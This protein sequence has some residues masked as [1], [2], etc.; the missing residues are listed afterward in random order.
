M[1][2]IPKVLH[3]VTDSSSSA[4][5]AATIKSWATKNPDWKVNVWCNSQSM[6]QNHAV[7]GGQ[8]PNVEVKPID[9]NLVPGTSTSTSS[10]S[11]SDVM[12]LAIL[13]KYGGC[14]IDTD[15][16]PADPLPS[17]N[18]SDNTA[19][20][21]PAKP[22]KQRRA[23]MACTI[24]SQRVRSLLAQTITSNSVA[25]ERSAMPQDT[26]L[27]DHCFVTTTI[28]ASTTTT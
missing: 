18:A 14:A 5:T 21:V 16:L 17:L 2:E 10:S 13:S 3:F 28:P 12:R 24:G 27:P 15:V 6:G 11:S 8:A 19:L 4:T 25:L 20:W 9:P 7:A 22:G 1:P 26:D 23:A